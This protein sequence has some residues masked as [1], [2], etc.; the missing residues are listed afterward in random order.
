[1]PT[2]Q[3]NGL[4]LNYDL[5]GDPAAPP[6]VLVMG[7]GLPGL[8]WPDVFVDALVAHGFRV[9]RFDNRDCGHSS[10]L[11]TGPMPNLPAAIAKALLRLRVRAP[12]D[13]DDMAADTAGLLDALGIDKAHVV[14]VSMGGMIAQMLAARFPARVLSLTSI[15]SSS[16]NPSPRVALGKRRALRAIIS[17]P[18]DP[19]SVDAVVNHLVG[20][21]GVIGSPGFPTP[22]EHLKQ[23]LERIAR[24]GLFPLGTARQLLGILASGDRRPAIR[25]IKAPTLVIHGADDPLVPVAAGIDTAANIPG[26]K[27]EVIA[28]MGHDFAPA[29]QPR[30][31]ATIAAHCRAAAPAPAATIGAPPAEPAPAA[32][33]HPESVQT[34]A[35]PA[36]EPLPVPFE[37]SLATVAPTPSPTPV[38][39]PFSP[40]GGDRAPVEPARPG[41]TAALP[42]DAGTPDRTP[43]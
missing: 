21:F 33:V 29:L 35:A 43:A 12:Y 19:T 1:M 28:G 24:H 26:A 4:T 39:S 8:A 22:L 15:M 36:P 27:V 38:A 9:I 42:R 23:N 11:G 6:I 2:A 18:A 37:A 16:G 31:A 17:R 5:F 20:V 25:T 34:A 30:L 32:P 41:G 10:K 13:L 40:A 7:L 3:A 14:G